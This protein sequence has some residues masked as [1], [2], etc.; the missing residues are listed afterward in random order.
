MGPFHVLCDLFN[1]N[2]EAPLAGVT[3][4]HGDRGSR[5]TI[6][7]HRTCERVRGMLEACVPSTLHDDLFN[8]HQS[9]NLNPMSS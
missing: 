2:N 3:C 5:S 8:A 1:G 6:T 9:L 4:M 7:R